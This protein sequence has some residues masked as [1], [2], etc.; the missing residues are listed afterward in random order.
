MDTQYI[1]N[2]LALKQPLIENCQQLFAPV[3]PLIMGSESEY[4]VGQDADG[5]PLLDLAR[6]P[7]ILINGGEVYHD[8]GHLEYA[9]PEV[10]NPAALVAYY[11]AGKIFCRR[12]NYSHRLFCNNNDWEGNTFAAHENYFTTLPRSQWHKLVPAL[13]ARTVFAGAGWQTNTGFRISQR[14]LFISEVESEHTTQRRGIINTRREPLGQVKGY[15]RLHI[16]CGDATMSEIATFMKFGVIA[17]AL[18]LIEGVKCQIQT[19]SD[20]HRSGFF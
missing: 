14:A 8:C 18:E 12:E 2:R 7:Q 20:A 1:L 17:L 5:E 9:S 3:R 4:G 19:R 6:L 15:D 13:I 10:S 11:G 16:I